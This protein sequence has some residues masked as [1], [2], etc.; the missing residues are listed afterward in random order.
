MAYPLDSVTHDFKTAFEHLKEKEELSTQRFALQKEQ[1][2]NDSVRRQ[3]IENIYL[4]ISG[5]DEKIKTTE[6]SFL[7]RTQITIVMVVVVCCFSV[8]VFI[9]IY[10]RYRNRRDNSALFIE[11]SQIQ[12]Q[13]EE[14]IRLIQ[15][16]DTEIQQFTQNNGLLET[17]NV[18]KDKLLSVISHDLRSP[19]S[20][21][22][23]F[24]SLYHTNNIARTDLVDFFCKLLSRVEN[25]STMLEN[26]LHWSKYQLKG[27]EPIFEKVNLQMIIDECINLYCMQAEQKHILIDNSLKT[28]VHVS[29][30]AEMLK[31]ILRNLISNA[32][33]FTHS[34]GIITI[35]TMTKEKFAIISVKDT[36][37]GISPEN[38]VKLFAMDNFTTPGTEKEKG[39]GLGLMLCKDF[40]EHNNGK[41]WLDSKL[42]AGTTFYI[43]IPLSEEQFEV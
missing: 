39:T 30:D 34:R 5:M 16:Y 14:L 37:V 7:F 38:Q 9:T 3:A 27:L 17:T 21:L 31:V 29:A 8:V 11:N 28:S 22:Q 15:S 40:V 43:S 4:R 35:M 25:T 19:I 23:A 20:S 1:I 36:G 26:L 6:K 24:L 10:R 18:V 12:D 42:N 32:L 13:A 33:K 2:I 41:I